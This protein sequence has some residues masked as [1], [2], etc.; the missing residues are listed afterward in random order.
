MN[1]LDKTISVISPSWA[2]GRLRARLQIKAYEAA[3]PTRLHKGR[4]ERRNANQLTQLGGQS[5]RE[6]ARWLDSNHDLVIGILDKMEERVVGAKGII[7]E[8]QPLSITGQIHTD[9][10]A[11]IRTA[12]A[13]WSI[14]PDVTGQ[15]TRPML[16]RL[17]VRTWLRD[18]EVFAQIVKGHQKGLHKQAGIPFWLEALEPDFVPISLND[19]ANRIQQGIELNEWGRPIAYRVHKNLLTP[20]Q[21]MGNLKSIKADDMLHLK[22]VRRLHQLRGNS[23]FTGILIRLSALKDYED[24]ELTAARIA[25]SM[26]MYIKKG[27]GQDYEG[28]QDD[29]REGATV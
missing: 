3:N 14:K 24:A 22:Y 11:Q 25:A 29:D 12:W 28:S 18:G 26:G 17:M 23:M 6:Q 8:P 10:A 2:S 1:I 7:I 15:Y 13:E 19:P 4:R 16:E 5:V 21:Q 20:G 9:L 27:E